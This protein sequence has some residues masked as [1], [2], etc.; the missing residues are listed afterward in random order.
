V[1]IL[2]RDTTPW[3]IV[4]QA[5][6][7]GWWVACCPVGVCD[8]HPALCDLRLLID[9]AKLHAALAHRDRVEPT[10]RVAGRLAPRHLWE[11][12]NADALGDVHL[13]TRL[14]HALLHQHCYPHPG[15]VPT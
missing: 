11:I 3:E 6:S 4:A 7:D 10:V 15:V 1:I 2:E 14:Y 8:W 5:R 9:S 12:A 13:R